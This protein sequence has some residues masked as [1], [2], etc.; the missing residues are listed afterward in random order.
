MEQKQME[1]GNKR[2]WH[3]TQK[4]TRTRRMAQDDIE[5]EK[6]KKENFVVL[7]NISQFETP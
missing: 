5:L 6:K 7:H 1:G 3:K 2:K 4:K